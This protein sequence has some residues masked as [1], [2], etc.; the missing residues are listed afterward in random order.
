MVESDYPHADSTWPDTQ[1]VLEKNFGHL[2]D[3]ELRMVAAGN[4]RPAVPPPL[5]PADDWRDAGAPAGRH[6]YGAVIAARDARWSTPTATS[7]SPARPGR[8]SPSRTGPASTRDAHG[9]EHVVVD[10]TEILAVPLGT[11]A[12]PGARFSDPASFLSLEE[13]Q[14]GGSD[15]VARLADM[16]TEGIDQ[17]VLFPSVGLYFWALDDPRGRRAHRPRLQRLAGLVLR[18]RPRPAVRG[19]HAA[20]AGP[21]RRRGRAAPGPP[22]AR[23][24][25]RLRAA[26]PLPGPLVVA[27]GPTSRCGRR[28]RRPA[29]AVAV[30]EGS[31]VIVPTLG[32]DRP[33]NPLVLH[34]VS[35]AF[36]EMLACAQLIAFGVLE[37]HPELR[38]VFLESGGGWAPFWLERL[39]EQA[40]SF[41]GFCP[42][43]RLAP[44]EYFA[45]QCWISYEVDEHT[46]PALAPFIGERAHRVGIGLPAPRR[47]LPG[48]GGRAAPHHGAAA[49]RRRRPR[50]LGDQR[51]RALR[52]RRPPPSGGADAVLGDVVREAAARYGRHP[53]LRHPRRARADL[54]RPR[55]AV[56]RGRRRPA[57]PRGVR[58]GDV[59]AL[60]LPSGPAYAV[61]YAAAAKIG[62]VT[63]GVNDRLS[64]PERR[65]CLAVAAAPARGGVARARR[66][67]PT[68]ARCPRS[69]D[70]VEVD[71]TTGHRSSVL[72]RAASRGHGSARDRPT[73]RPEPDPDRPVAV[74]FTSGTT[75]EP[76]G[77]V[78]AWRQLEAIGD[79][80]GGGRWGGGGRGLSSTSFAHLGY[81]T[82]LPQALRGG[83]TTFLMERWSA[84]DALEMVERHRITTLGGIPT[85]V[86][87]MLRHERFDVHRHEQRA[88]HRHGGRARPPPRWCARP[89]RASACPWSSAT[90]APRRGWGW[91]RRPTTPPRT[92][93]RRVGRARR[94]V[95]LTIRSDDDRAAPGR[96]RSATC[97]C[98]R[99]R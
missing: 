33:F 92:P 62:A 77:A 91:G 26:Q 69:G 13:A 34:A 97:A 23:L 61:A 30:H 10:D 3:D 40:E 72:R 84:G 25:G 75:G 43:L 95:E 81:M 67:T 9:Y 89:G 94:G 22:R 16:D 5:P 38:V 82:K 80:D 49:R 59:V 35:H 21:R 15:P 99:R 18:G 11:L 63:A 12:T 88:R 76:K 37:R 53:A 4:A 85:Q 68:S 41:G 19:G 17:A 64:P 46:L 8:R 24:R 29:T 96:A 55:P 66:S 51:R 32:A 14:P 27:T 83:G 47:H 45:R 93:R 58:G 87:L 65:R 6:R 39:D 36:E 56:G 86:A 44:S 71:P 31:S 70:V 78:F 48:R 42:E 7:S 98:A 20:D 2:P 90:R 79:I 50:I 60:L 28:P 52:A 73:P 1:I 74:V 57:R 54:R